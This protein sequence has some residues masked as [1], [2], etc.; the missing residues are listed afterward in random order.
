MI[1]HQEKPEKKFM[2]RM[3]E[4]K[5]IATKNRISIKVKPIYH[6]GLSIYYRN[7]HVSLI[8]L[9]GRKEDYLN[10]LKMK[11]NQPQLPLRQKEV[12]EILEKQI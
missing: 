11:K 12:E 3:K 4:K 2:Y 7:Q 8:T 10:I 6:N 9:L 1:R 5:T